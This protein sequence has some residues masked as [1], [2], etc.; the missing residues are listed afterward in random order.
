MGF[1][2]KLKEKMDDLL[3]DKDKDK[4]QQ[5]RESTTRYL[6]LLLTSSRRQ[7][8]RCLRQ[9]LP[10]WRSPEQPVWWPATEL[11]RSSSSPRPRRSAWRTSSSSGVGE[12]VGSELKPLVLHRTGDWTQPVGATC[13]SSRQ[14]RPV[15]CPA[16]WCWIRVGSPHR[17]PRAT[18]LTIYQ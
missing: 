12:T 8:P 4:Q 2:D 10:G 11:R 14:L 17:G 13:P 5:Q 18:L 9:L 16:W 7:R 3:D 1:L 15:W 6:F